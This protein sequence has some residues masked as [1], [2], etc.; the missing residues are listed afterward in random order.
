ME[1]L[2]I[3]ID[4]ERKQLIHLIK[5]SEQAM[6]LYD[7][8]S[9]N[10]EAY[11]NKIPE[12]I[13]IGLANNY[14]EAS[15]IHSEAYPL[16]LKANELIAKVISGTNELSEEAT[17]KSLEVTYK[18]FLIILLV[19]VI[20]LLLAVFIAFFI[21]NI[22]SKPIQRLNASAILIAKG[23]LTGEPIMLKSRDELG[24]LNASFNTMKVS[25][26]AM[27][28]SVSKTSEQVGASS[29][30]LLASAEQNKSASGKISRT[31][32]QLAV[33]TADQVNMVNRSLQEMTQMANNSKQ[34]SEL[35]KSVSTS[36]VATVN[37]SKNGNSIIHN[38]VEQMDTVR[39]S[40]ASLTELVIGLG[41]RSAEIGIITETINSI[42]HQTN[43]LAMNAAIEAAHAGEHGKGF[44]VVATEVR[45]L[46]KE[47]SE[48][49]QK[50]TDLVEIIQ[51]DTNHAIQ[52]VKVN[53]SE[54]EAGIK[55]VNA[56]GQAFEQISDAVKKVA[57]DIQEVSERSQEMSSSTNGLVRY[58][59][60]ISNVAEDA[61]GGV[62][63][64]T[65]ITEEQL[66]SMEEITSSAN[67][68]SNM[69]EELQERINK[70]KV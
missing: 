5:S 33:G 68:L 8:F 28:Q 42:A 69:A 7:E 37:Q 48:F 34:I 27:I 25:L 18:S 16:W 39:N 50:I 62:H 67:S 51:N 1:Q 45:K 66:A 9:T 40:L 47:S 20:S 12:F 10:Y 30:E 56:A 17:D 2:T 32:E 38:A 13:E 44:T 29:E 22:F 26:H 61:S 43:L 54:T 59:Q 53:N 6:E 41:E 36:A 58:M 11:L 65:A 19:T 35:A 46:S 21:A 49:A 70:F 3:K 31:I 52:A 15:R 14:E 57:G 24:T 55:I 63:N 60:Q 4:D 23:D 64:V